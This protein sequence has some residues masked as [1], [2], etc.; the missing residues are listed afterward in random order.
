[1]EKINFKLSFGDPKF[2]VNPKERWV[3]C[4]VDYY[5]NCGDPRWGNMID[6]FWRT[7]KDPLRMNVTVQV[8]SYE[9]EFNEEIGKK[10]ARTR[11]ES[12]AYKRVM[13]FFKRYMDM[14][15]DMTLAMQEFFEKAHETV[16]HNDKYIKEN[17]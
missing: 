2:F 14:H 12:A 7:S 10:V 16:A 8:K 17:F 1:M 4:S 15:F 11:A 5:I 13:K 3:R 9:N 6:E